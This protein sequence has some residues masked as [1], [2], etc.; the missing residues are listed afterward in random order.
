MSEQWYVDDVKPPLDSLNVGAK[1]R[2]YTSVHPRAITRRL[3]RQPAVKSGADAHVRAQPGG[4]RRGK[5]RIAFPEFLGLGQGPRAFNDLTVVIAHEL[6]SAGG[7]PLGAAAA[8]SLAISP[9]EA[10]SQACST[11]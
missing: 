7:I 11:A 6:D 8:R 4:Q 10:R 3:E 1:L 2:V 5:P 9:S